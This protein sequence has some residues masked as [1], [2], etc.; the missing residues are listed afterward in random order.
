MFPIEPNLYWLHNIFQKSRAFSDYL[1]SEKNND[2]FSEAIP[3][4][5]NKLSPTY[6]NFINF[7]AENLTTKPWLMTQKQISSFIFYDF[8]TTELN[9][10]NGKISSHVL[11]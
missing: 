7:D 10:M 8:E 6:L 4:H 3:K 9:V 1:R 5:I 11:T 2:I